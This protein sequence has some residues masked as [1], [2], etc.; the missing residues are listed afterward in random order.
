L[1]ELKE[2]NLIKDLVVKNWEI[3]YSFK[4]SSIIWGWTL[5]E[6]LKQNALKTSEPNFIKYLIK[7]LKHWG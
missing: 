6:R 3:S 5:E 4:E 7:A 2:M 1:N